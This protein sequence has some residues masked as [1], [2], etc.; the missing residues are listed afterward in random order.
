MTKLEP[1]EA[2][3]WLI[4]IL[5]PLCRVCKTKKARPL[6]FCP[7]THSHHKILGGKALRTPAMPTGMLT[8]LYF[9]LSQAPSSQGCEFIFPMLEERCCV[10]VKNQTLHLNLDV[11]IRV[12]PF[13]RCVALGQRL[14]FSKPHWF[15][16]LRQKQWQKL[17]VVMETS[18]SKVLSTQLVQAERGRHG[19]YY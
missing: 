4:I 14:N 19:N 6:A 16:S 12:L 5:I 11:C 18:G 1:H 2:H 13:P 7:V 3:W 8:L 17:E 9:P 10:V 15:S